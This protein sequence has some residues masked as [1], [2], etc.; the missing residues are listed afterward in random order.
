MINLD[1][2][3]DDLIRH[4]GR[5]L[6]AYH[7]SL[8]Y[9]TIGVGHCIDK[10]RGGGLPEHIVDALLEHDIEVATRAAVAAVPDLVYHPEPVRRA[11]VEMAFQLGR[12]GLL[13]FRRMRAALADKD[14]RSAALQALESRWARQTPQRAREIA[15]LIVSAAYENDT[16]E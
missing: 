11:L 16:S 5:V 1:Q 14:Y 8:G 10:R 3:R 12:D 6:H 15:A 13:G 4:E 7:D 2:L 9:W